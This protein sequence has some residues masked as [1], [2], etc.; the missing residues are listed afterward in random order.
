MSEQKIVKRVLVIEDDRF[1]SEV[2][3]AKLL[4]DGFETILASDGENAL[5]KAEEDKPDLILLDI[6]MPK[7]SGID[8]LRILKEKDATRD[9]PVIM[10]TNSTEEE[11]V[12]NAMEMGAK[13]YLIKSNYTPE[14]IV[15]KV[16]RHCS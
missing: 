3:I 5:K 10:L 16:A 4:K 15:Q 9:I 7:I 14:E 11:H 2:Y 8:V 6:F 13:D 12:G 1:I